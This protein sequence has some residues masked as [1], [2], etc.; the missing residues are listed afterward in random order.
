MINNRPNHLEKVPLYRHLPAAPFTFDPSALPAG[1]NMDIFELCGILP[2][3]LDVSDICPEYLTVQPPQ[4]VFDHYQSLNMKFQTIFVVANFYDL[5]LVD[6]V[7]TGRPY[8]ISLIPG[9]KRGRIDE[10]GIEFAKIFP[11]EGIEDLGQIYLNYDP[12]EGAWGLFG[13]Y[14]TLVGPD[15]LKTYTDSIGFVINGYLLAKGYNKDEVIMSNLVAA[16][17][18]IQQKYKNYRLNRYFKP[19][20]EVKPRKIW[21]VDSPIELFLVQSLAAAGAFPTIQTLIFDSGEIY[22]SFHDMVFTLDN[23]M[24]HQ[25]VTEVD[26]YFSEQK[27]AVFCDSTKHHRAKKAQ[28]KDQ[29]IDEKLRALGI[30]PV[31]I[32][33]RDIVNSLNRVTNEIL[34]LL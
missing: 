25:L 14:S 26:L 34:N 24:E 5:R 9:S 31:R 29:K 19:F 27:I 6:N 12:F 23:D 4:E 32:K 11:Y 15:G 3:T 10:R 17:R 2:I 8:C 22:P 28:S 1:L 30:T 16:D 7:V 21:G 18:S 20:S 13:K 33:G